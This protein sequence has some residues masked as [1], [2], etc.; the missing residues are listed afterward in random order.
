MSFNVA[1][2]PPASVTPNTMPGDEGREQV[3][4]RKITMR[5]KAYAD[6]PARPVESAAD[7]AAPT[8]PAAE[9]TAP[10]PVTAPPPSAETVSIEEKSGTSDNI[11]QAK[12]AP[13]ETKPLSPQYAELA[14]QRRSLQVKERELVERER[15][16]TSQAEGKSDWIDPAALKSQPLSVLLKHGVTYDQLTEAILADRDGVNPEII[17]LRK[18]IQDLKTG[19]DKSFQEREQRSEQQ[20]LAEM[21]REA[22]SLAREG[23]EFAV[24]RETKSIPLVMRLIERTYRET[25]EV[26]DVAEAMR[27]VEDELMQES[28]KVA[29]LN[30]IKAKFVPPATP[31]TQSP[32][33]TPAAQAVQ[34]PKQKQM[35]TLSSRDSAS[36][37]MSA[38]QRAI[39]A[40]NGTLQK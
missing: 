37:V 13:E 34:E 33:P 28:V 7:T 11:G 39:A 2:I 38:K 3:S 40:F 12:Q 22:E 25:G 10:A 4:A 29:A 30:K 27:L 9:V 1:P 36:T 31:P 18:E 23:E 35:R 6:M 20:A 21:R 5:T 26:L 17:A 19:V 16:L 24:V 15:A 8:A 14:R 32:A